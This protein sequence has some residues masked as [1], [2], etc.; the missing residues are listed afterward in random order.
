MS[1]HT[2]IFPATAIAGPGPAAAAPGTA[3]TGSPEFRRLL[4]S[5]EKLRRPAAAAPT[6]GTDSDAE[7]LQRALHTADAEFSAAMD[8]RRRLEEAF[9]ARMQ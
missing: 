8:L 2:V 6:S 3:T 4:D 9:R 1:D 5:L 7:R